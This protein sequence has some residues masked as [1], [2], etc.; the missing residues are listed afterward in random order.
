M[1]KSSFE[2]IIG[3]QGRLIYTCVG[4]SMNPL[5]KEGDLLVISNVTRPLKKYDI[6]LYKRDNGQYVLHRIIDI[7]HGG[8]VMCGDNRDIAERGI[9]DRHII[10]VLTAVI[11][12][13]VE[14]PV[15]YPITDLYTRLWYS[16]LSFRKLVFRAK[17]FKR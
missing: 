2:D 12:D 17:R 10:G 14:S 3:E 8:Y 7:E 9:G 4:D 1:T 5:I 11:R 16:S 13:G 15:G 6:P